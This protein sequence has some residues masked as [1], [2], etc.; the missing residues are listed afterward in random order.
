MLDRSSAST[1]MV[2]HIDGTTVPGAPLRPE[3]L[4]AHVYLP[5]SFL[6]ENPESEVAVADMVQQ[7]IEYVGV[8]TATSWTRRACARNW[9][10]TQRSTVVA[11][12]PP[13]MP[14][15]PDPIPRS[16]HYIFRGR[17]ASGVIVPDPSAE[18]SASQDS[19]VSVYDIDEIELDST[20]SALLSAVEHNSYLETEI[21]ELTATASQ[22]EEQRDMMAD[23]INDYEKRERAHSD[24]AIAAQARIDS[25]EAEVYRLR[26]ELAGHCKSFIIGSHTC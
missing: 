7:F 9:P 19:Q 15:I 23:V 21:K 10:F 22:F 26:Y 13:D 20:A 6:Q 5:P 25:L 24:Q 12:S 1:T 4:K 18:P 17:R 11:P 2:L 8:P 3:Y 14:L 16:S